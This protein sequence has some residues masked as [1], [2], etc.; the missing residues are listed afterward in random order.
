MQMGSP[1][2]CACCDDLKIN[3]CVR[4]VYLFV[5]QPNDDRNAHLYVLPPFISSPYT[6]KMVF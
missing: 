4:L 3:I 5:M 6:V 2:G 1:A